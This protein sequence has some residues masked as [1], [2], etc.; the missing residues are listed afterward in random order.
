MKTNLKI[1]PI[2]LAACFTLLFN[3]RVF[4]QIKQLAGY[5]KNYHF[6]HSGNLVADKNFYLLTV[7]EHTP[8]VSKLVS[9]NNTLQTILTK[10]VTEL[11]QHAN[12][13]CFMPASLLT[14][15]RYNTQDSTQ[16]SDVFKELYSANKSVFDAM[17]NTHLRPSGY[18]QR[19]V[20][21]NNQELLLKAWAQ[22]VYGI[23]YIIDQFGF[24]KKL[25]FPRIDTASYVVTSRYY[26]GVMKDMFSMLDEHTTEMKL[27][28]QPSL[29][30][31]MGLMDANDRDEPARFEP[32][33][34]KDNKKAFDRIKLIQWDKYKYATIVIPGNGPELFTTPISPDNK[35]HCDI[36][37]DR[38]L[39]GWAPFIIVSGGYCYPF[40]GPYCEAIQMKKYLMEK[41]SIPENAIIIDP[42]ARH[43]T[44]NFRNANRLIIRYGIPVD[45]QSVFITAKMQASSVKS[46]LFDKR[47]MHDLGY[48]P[49]REK[50]GISNHDITFYPTYESLHMDP[51]DPLDP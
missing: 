39:K 40:R 9:T 23:N 1:Y 30:I 3:N 31:A 49:Y 19:F 24:G 15:F 42:H 8:A 27:F 13:T 47:N 37:A 7:I 12:D 18:Y 34:Q 4:A 26:R 50:T 33:E 17:I 46:D 48:L 44:T 2:L 21:L 29:A 16:I 35:I 20:G 28:Y 32:M 45:K 11:K 43:T 25:R 10:R 36:A 14:G 5:D 51:L 22:Y 41:F 38:Y 6:V